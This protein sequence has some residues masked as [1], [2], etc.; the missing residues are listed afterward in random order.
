MAKS[1]QT[2]SK[3]KKNSEIEKSNYDLIIA[4][5]LFFIATIEIFE[6]GYFGIFISDIFDLLFGE[7]AILASIYLIIL[8]VL[9]LTKRLVV[10]FKSMYGTIMN[11]VFF[12]SFYIYHLIFLYNERDV[13]NLDMYKELTVND[14]VSHG[15]GI[16]IHAIDLM[17]FTLFGGVGI[18]IP[19]I[20]LIVACVMLI[21][22]LEKVKD[23]TAS[24]EN[25]DLS[26]KK[27]KEKVEEVVKPKPKVKKATTGFSDQDINQLLSEDDFLETKP[28][29]F[30]NEEPSEEVNSF[31]DKMSQPFSEESEEVFEETSSEGFSALDFKKSLN[32]TMPKFSVAN[33]IKKEVIEEIVED[34]VEDIIEPASSDLTQELVV[35]EGKKV[36]PKVGKYS[37]PPI[38]LL[39]TFDVKNSNVGAQN[40]FAK[41][42]GDVLISTL[43]SFKI[44]ATIDKINI[45]PNII[46]YELLPE[47]GTKVAKF[48]SL[49]N[50]IALA[51]AASSVRI[52][53]PIPGKSAIGIEIPNQKPKIIGLKEVLGSKFND[54]KNLL[55]VGLGIDITGKP[56]FCDIKTTP[57]MLVA[58]STGSG[59]SVCINSIIVSILAKAKPEEVKLVLVDPKKVEL[60]PFNGIP[61]LLT[62]VVTDPKKA[63]YVLSKMV[64]EMEHRYE[65]FA[66]TSTRNILGYNE[67][68]KDKLPYIVIIIDELADLMMVASKEVE[69]SIARIAQMARAAGIHLIVATQRPSTDV[70]TGLIKANI[71]T[72]VSFAVSSSIDSRTILDSIG[73]EKLLGKGDMLIMEQ[74]SPN[75]VRLQGAYLS[76][77]EVYSV[78]DYINSQ[79]NEVEFVDFDME[80]VNVEN[81]GAGS[82]LDPLYESVKRDVINM[83]K[84]STSHIQRHYKVGY[85]RATTIMEQ[86]ESRGIVSPTEGTKPRRVLV[87]EED[88]DIY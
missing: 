40:K 19:A 44:K 47:V 88:A 50:D 64:E 12:T 27:P 6:A 36:T 31:Y 69:S 13:I 79:G 39:K 56:V 52:E 57:H 55:Q 66:E 16:F 60:T 33:D 87:R 15:A 72:R 63:A 2:K 35:T 8:A 73:A 84:A 65:L 53:A 11:L 4:F 77:D 45:G 71:P 51:L 38:D 32:G 61:H 62:P 81:F 78:V 58:G 17:L 26:I 49:S 9:L 43:A 14:N 25:G 54:P 86:L 42:K 7:A 82:D 59:K 83:Q 30:F 68:V 74:S 85:N 20:L 75:L 10:F 80:E 29:M 5:L 67:K 76:D 3:P 18:I 28:S 1:S 23:L 22:N 24:L 34:V 48:S 46:K 70:I 41:D 21:L 37:I